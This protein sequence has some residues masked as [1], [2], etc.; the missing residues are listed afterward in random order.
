MGNIQEE[1]RIFLL[2]KFDEMIYGY[3]NSDANMVYINS[4]NPDYKFMYFN[5]IL[6]AGQF[7][8]S[9]RWGIKQNS[10][11]LDMQ[12][13]RESDENQQALLNKEI[14]LLK[15]FSGLKVKLTTNCK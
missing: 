4:I 13:F 14:L 15:R 3:K 2:P 5:R 7:I 10:I 6:H 8:G 9:W 1:N 12:F 11:N